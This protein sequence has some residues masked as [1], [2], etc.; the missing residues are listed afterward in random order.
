MNDIVERVLASH[1][2]DVSTEREKV[3]HYLS[4]LASAGKTD[5]E[6]FVIGKAYLKEVL[7]P[8]PRYSGC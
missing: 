2:G 7:E 3:R 8:D 5:E 6:L 4:L 1:G